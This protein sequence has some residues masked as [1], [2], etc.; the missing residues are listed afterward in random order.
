MKAGEFFA[1]ETKRTLAAV[2]VSALALGA[3]LAGWKPAGIDPSWL[4]IAVC[5]IPIVIGAAVALVRDHDITADMLVSMALVSSVCLGEYFAAGEVAFIMQIGTLLEDYTSGRAKKGIEK[6]IKLTPQTARVKRGSGVRI[7]AAEDVLPG[8]I[9]VVIAG[10]TIAVDGVIVSGETSIDASVVTGESLPVEKKAGDRVMSG[11][12]NCFGTFEMRAEKACAD[13]SLERMIRLAQQADANKAPIVGLA[14]KWAAWMV[15]GALIIA[16]VTFFATGRI[17]RAVTVLVVFCPCAFVLATPTAIMAGIANAARKGILVRSGDALERLAQIDCAAFDKTGTL[18]RGRPALCRIVPLSDSWT[19]D[20]LL[21]YAAAAERLSEHP[22]GAAIVEYYDRKGGKKNPASGFKMSAGFGVSALVKGRTVLAGKAEF[23][24]KAGIDIPAA[25]D[26]AAE[27]IGRAGG[28]AVYVA[29]DGA[30][31]GLIGL[32]DE[33]RPETAQTIAR[34]KAEGLTPL[35]LTGDS[36]AAARSVAAAAG[37]DECRYNLL[38]EEKMA[39]VREFSDAGRKLCMVGDGVNDALALSS[40][41][42]G[43]AMGGVGSDIA[44][45]SSDAVLVSDGLAGLP[46]LFHIARRSMIKV[47]Q[48][49]LISLGINLVAVTLSV[50]GFLNPVTGALMHNCGSVL[51]VINAAL[52][53]GEKGKKGKEK[54]NAGTSLS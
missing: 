26:R 36:S 50:L 20:G 33:L 5:G 31:A 6:L 38:P 13:S 39:V 43:I 22:L 53:L 2:C 54:P 37:I 45:E 47:R 11:T 40:A 1:D 52:L 35:M 12:V 4:A 25:A 15:I 34:L 9:L 19:E 41:Y 8:D 51:V 21:E 10:E 32:A 27:E 17:I 49:I 3:S 42:A 29:V 28:T 46:W 14:D 23:L 7:I 44:V 18:T 48:S 30:A 16:V 24:K